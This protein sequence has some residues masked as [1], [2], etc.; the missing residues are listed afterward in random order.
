MN[1][2]AME[3]PIVLAFERGGEASRHP[4]PVIDERRSLPYPNGWVA[5]CF[6]HEIK[7]GEVRITPFMGH[8]LVAYRTHAGQA[9]VVNPY[10]PHLGAHLGH[11]GKVDGEDLVC[12]FHG[13]AFG[14]D[15][16]CVRSGTGQKPPFATLN[17]WLV[18]ERNGMV[19]V[20]RDSAG[21]AP[22]WDVPE[23]D[24]TGYSPPKASCYELG[25]YPHDMAE[26]SSDVAHF[27]WLHGF[28]DVAMTYETDRIRMAFNLT[29]RWHGVQINMR[30]TIYGLGYVI[31]ESDVPSLGVK[32]KTSGCATP[33]ARLKWTFRWT[34]IVHIS[35][36][37]AL[38]AILRTPAYEIL[39]SL[40]HRW[41][42]RLVRDDFP[43]WSH[44][45]YVEHPKL[46]TG[47]ASVAAFRRWMTQFYPN[48]QM[49]E[50]AAAEVS[51]RAGGKDGD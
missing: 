19:F 1:R 26:N 32:V 47:E 20:W 30:I 11:G 3:Q 13:L 43:I 27:A 48:G 24:T 34:D 46:V 39:I 5:V 16:A 18:H 36:F 15:G 50:A 14:P 38:P 37:N 28:T 6:S 29:G 2:M 31:A 42:I 22:D 41:F 21:R 25:G 12:P 17:S 23:A 35:S 51:A 7:P 8:E 49:P 4:K 10:C 33:T 45:N 40:A 9:H 44:R